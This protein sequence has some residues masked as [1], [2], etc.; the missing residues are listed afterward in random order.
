MK[1]FYHIQLLEWLAHEKP[2]QINLSIKNNNS[3]GNACKHDAKLILHQ[4][5]ST[6]DSQY[7]K[8]TRG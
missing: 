7:G 2:R 3:Y 6:R 5:T 8:P 4:V 1:L